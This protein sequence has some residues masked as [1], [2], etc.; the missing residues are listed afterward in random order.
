VSTG[1]T[2]LGHLAPPFLMAGRKPGKRGLSIPPT[3]PRGRRS[4]RR[5]LARQQADSTEAHS[6][7]ASP[8]D[9]PNTVI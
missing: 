3:I 1:V 8:F 5:A 9:S 6:P 7:Q 4:A 2:Q